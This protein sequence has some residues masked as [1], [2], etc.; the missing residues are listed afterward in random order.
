M[1][2]KADVRVIFSL[3]VVGFYVTNLGRKRWKLLNRLKKTITS[4]IATAP[5]G[6]PA[7]IKG[8]VFS[9]PGDLIVSPLTQTQ[10]AAF[11]WEI[12][13][14]EMG[15]TGRP[16]WQAYSKFHSIP[17]LYLKDDGPELAGVD[18]EHA[19]YME[20]IF[21]TTLEVSND[22]S[23]EAKALI[24]NN[25]LMIISEEFPR[26]YRIKEK[27]FL[28]EEEFFIH[29]LCTEPP[30]SYLHTILGEA[31][32]GRRASFNEADGFSEKEYLAKTRAFFRGKVYFTAKSEQE[33]K[34]KL[35]MTSILFLISGPL[36]LLYGLYLLLA[37]FI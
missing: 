17:F 5:L 15:I 3:I 24:K 9:L 29:G 10:G 35:L 6:V 37:P 31:K 28:P 25:D 2:R 11:I 14:W 12:D 32:V 19:E 4:N 13:E 16:G 8:K 7:E 26:R 21:T 27:V 22:L 36:M 30:I 23:A 20:D 18:L 33:A 34:T 1:N